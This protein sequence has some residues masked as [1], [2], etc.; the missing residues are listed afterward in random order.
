[1]G[2]SVA[3]ELQRE[4]EVTV[5]VVACRYH[6]CNDAALRRQLR[7]G[8]GVEYEEAYF[9]AQEAQTSEPVLN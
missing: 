8:F 3:A 1:V 9:S 2:L 7:D 4:P 5:P 6:Y